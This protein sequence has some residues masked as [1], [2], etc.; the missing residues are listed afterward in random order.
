MFRDDYSSGVEPPIVFRYGPAALALMMLAIPILVAM[1]IVFSSVAIYLL[2]RPVSVSFAMKLDS[3]VVGALGLAFGLIGFTALRTWY[4]P[5]TVY[6]VDRLGIKVHLFSSEAFLQWDQM[7][8][9]RYRTVL[10]Q[11][12]IE[13]NGASRTVVLSNVDMNIGRRRVRAALAL[14]DQVA[15][16]RTRR[17]IF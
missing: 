7:K 1:C 5:L 13:F 9:A 14:I 11:I 12:D 8:H 15:P 2:T 17:T 16:H 10:G 4:A 3:I 6:E